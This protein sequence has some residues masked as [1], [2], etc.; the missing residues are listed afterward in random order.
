MNEVLV[1]SMDTEMRI[2]K[3]VKRHSQRPAIHQPSTEALDPA[4]ALILGL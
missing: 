1:R 3:T 4:D 2:G